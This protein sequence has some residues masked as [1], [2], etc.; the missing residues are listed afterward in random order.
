[1]MHFCDGSAFKENELFSSHPKALQI[2]AY[3]DELEIVSL[4]GTYV[5]KYK[6]GCLFFSWEMLGLVFAICAEVNQFGCCYEV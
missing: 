3:Y 4:I 5:K 1:M 2:V 6:L